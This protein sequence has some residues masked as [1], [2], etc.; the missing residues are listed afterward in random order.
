LIPRSRGI[1]HSH[2]VAFAAAL[3][4]GDGRMR[5][6]ARATCETVVVLR[7]GTNI[8]PRNSSPREPLVRVEHRRIEK[9][10]SSRP[11]P[12]QLRQSVHAEVEEERLQPH[13]L[14][15]GAAT[16]AAFSR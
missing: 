13:R 5:R 2:E 7:D 10:G 8:V 3:R 14:L 1:S 11:L 12:H 6:V 16:F 4:N 15:I 9:Q